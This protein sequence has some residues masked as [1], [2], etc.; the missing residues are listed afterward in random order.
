MGDEARPEIT[1]VD[2][3]DTVPGASAGLTGVLGVPAGSGPWPGVVLVHEAFG[4]SDLMRRHVERMARAGYL[5]LLPDL[6]AEGGARKCL[7]ETFRALATGQG[8]AFADLESARQALMART[9]CSGRVGVLGFCMGGGFA[10]VAA[11]RGFDVSSVNYGRLPKDLDATLAGACPI[12]ASY[13]GRD[14]SLPGAA[15]KLDTALTRLGIHHDV[16]EYPTA[17]HSF[18]NEA[19]T[20]GPVLRFTVNRI[21]GVGPNP[22]AA[23][24]A[25]RRIDAFFA[26][27]LGT[28]SGGSVEPPGSPPSR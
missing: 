17:G 3:E 1:D 4:I 15:R 24:D 25:W 8:R 2:I 11:S 14:K 19:E 6:F 16:K 12:V 21:L 28:R 22:D 23:A 18:L 9:D 27:H 10:L 5:A 7:L 13:G 20:Q 26:E